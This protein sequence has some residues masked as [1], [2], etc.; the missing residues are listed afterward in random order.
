MKLQKELII[1]VLTCADQ[2][3]EQCSANHS[4]LGYSGI[5]KRTRKVVLLFII[6]AQTNAFNTPL[7]TALPPELKTEKTVFLFKSDFFFFLNFHPGQI[8]P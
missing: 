2:G 7:A 4:H 8:N 6:W 5:T 1:F 3:A